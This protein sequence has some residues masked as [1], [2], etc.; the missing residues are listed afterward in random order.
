MDGIAGGSVK[1]MQKRF[2]LAIIAIRVSIVKR[3]SFLANSRSFKVLIFNIKTYR[4][5]NLSRKPLRGSIFK[6]RFK[7]F[8]STEGLLFET[9]CLE[10][11][12]F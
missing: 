6:R 9:E 10:E 2:L 3:W 7:D 11:M 1:K 12:I 8:F 4:G 5:P